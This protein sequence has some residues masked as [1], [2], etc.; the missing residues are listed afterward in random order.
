V[1]K[2]RQEFEKE[3][4]TIYQKHILQFTVV[5]CCIMP[6]Q[7]AA[8]ILGHNSALGKIYLNQRR[9]KQREVLF[10]EMSKSSD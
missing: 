2:Y 3:L 4:G 6:V 8:F 10:K 7:S 1:E 9:Q 5:K